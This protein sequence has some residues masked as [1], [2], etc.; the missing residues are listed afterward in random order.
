MNGLPCPAEVLNNKKWRRVLFFGSSDVSGYGLGGFC[1]PK[2]GGAA[3]S[4]QKV[5]VERGGPRDCVDEWKGRLY[6]R[7]VQWWSVLC[8]NKVKLSPCKRS[9]ILHLLRNP[10]KYVSSPSPLLPSPPSTSFPP[11]LS[12]PS[13]PDPNMT[14]GAFP[15]QTVSNFVTGRSVLTPD[16]WPNRVVK[17]LYPPADNSHGYG[18]AVD[19]AGYESH[20]DF[21]NAGAI[22]GT[23]L[24]WQLQDVSDSTLQKSLPLMVGKPGFYKRTIRSGKCYEDDRVVRYD[25]DLDQVRPGGAVVPR[26]SIRYDRV[27]LLCHGSRSGTT[28]WCVSIR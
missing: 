9:M 23:V 24:Q 7:P 11:S 1:K 13:Q 2:D 10:C 16:A 5:A 17:C 18:E 15:W 25:T 6:W 22:G 26:I 20:F 27:V 14:H 4:A 28:G 3:W 8:C 19:Y 12:R 21:L